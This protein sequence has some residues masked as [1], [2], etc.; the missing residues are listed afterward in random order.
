MILGKIWRAFKAQA[1]KVANFFWTADPI[2]QLQY[3]YDR[4][5]DQLKEGREGLEQYRAL[6]ER[7]T[8]QVDDNRS[9]VSRLEAKVRTYLKA[10]DRD[11]AARFA[12]DLQKAKKDLQ[13]NEAQL[14]LHQESYDNSLTKIKHAS[15]KLGQLRDKI[16][17]Y[18]A[19]L[20]LSR[21]EA[22]LSKVAQSINVDV[23]TDFGQIEQVLQDEID[24]NRAKAK[25]SVDLS[26]EG[27][28]EVR[29]EQAIEQ[30]LAEQALR[31]FEMEDSPRLPAPKDGAA[32]T[33]I[34]PRK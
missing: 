1:N 17:K 30:T 8:R 16:K 23:T 22:E 29:R 18:D 9:L 19:D 14:R 4:M 11:S 32:L 12:L 7:V 34:S 6:V 28:E 15:H 25:V 31:E 3:E 13:E 10:G 21:A 5:V 24:K 27:V 2:A 26:S 20:K 33:P